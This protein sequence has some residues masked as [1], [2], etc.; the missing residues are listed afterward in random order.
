MK[1]YIIAWLLTSVMT[2]AGLFCLGVFVGLFALIG[3][4][5]NPENLEANL[6]ASAAFNLFVFVGMAVI[7]F[8]S[9]KF[10]VKKFVVKD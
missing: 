5:S 2:F 8:F 7:N 1:E 9:F 6:Q 10:C 4:V 3:G